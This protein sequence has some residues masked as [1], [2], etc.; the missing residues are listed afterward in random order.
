[1]LRV[2][3]ASDSFGNLDALG[4]ALDIFAR[5]GAERIFFLGG[6]YA[7]VP[8]ALARRRAAASPGPDA[9]AGSPVDGGDFLAA[10]RSSL[11]HATA[12][13]GDALAG[14]ITRV[15]SRACPEVALGAPTKTVDMLEGLLCCLVHDKADLTREDISN[16]SLLFH[17]KSETAALVQIGPRVFMTPGSLNARAAEGRPATF[18]FLDLQPPEVE[19][20]VF[21]GDGAELRRERATLASG[22]KVSVK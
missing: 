6:W 1:V 17:G 19:L 3:L 18:A 7:D 9:A 8:A 22:A 10:V 4:V 21:S 20:V 13:M 5:V 16:A 15:A 11:S 14:R 12:T 2:G